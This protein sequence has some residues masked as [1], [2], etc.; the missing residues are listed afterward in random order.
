MQWIN[1]ASAW[2]CCGAA[3]VISH[4]DLFI[5]WKFTVLYWLMAIACWS[6]I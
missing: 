1:L 2:Y 3:T 4:N 6:A 5:I